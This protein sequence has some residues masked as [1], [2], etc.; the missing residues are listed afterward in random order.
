MLICLVHVSRQPAHQLDGRSSTETMLTCHAC[1]QSIRLEGDAVVMTADA[2]ICGSGAGGGVAA[3]LLAEAG[4]KAR[5]SVLAQPGVIGLSF[6]PV[7]AAELWS[8]KLPQ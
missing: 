3:A 5:P 4:A 2:V 7:S 8:C 6:Y 1:M